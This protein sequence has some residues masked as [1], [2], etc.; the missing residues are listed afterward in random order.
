MRRHVD[1]TNLCGFRLKLD[2]NVL[3]I[4]RAICVVNKMDEPA[5]GDGLGP[6]IFYGGQVQHGAQQ[7]EET[8]RVFFEIK[9]QT[10]G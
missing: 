4:K 6:N 3:I 1:D 8:P 10:S 9:K 7:L 2:S 5:D